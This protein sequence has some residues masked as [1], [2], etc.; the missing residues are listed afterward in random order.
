M[1]WSSANKTAALAPEQFVKFE[2]IIFIFDNVVIVA[3]P[4]NTVIE[5]NYATDDTK[6]IPLFA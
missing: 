4:L 1:F 3:N 6:K 5:S 2:F